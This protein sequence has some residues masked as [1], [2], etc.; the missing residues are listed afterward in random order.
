MKPDIYSPKYRLFKKNIET[1]FKSVFSI[2]N[3]QINNKKIT[4]ISLYC[5]IEKGGPKDDFSIANLHRILLDLASLFNGYIEGKRKI[6][7]GDDLNANK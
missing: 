7:L 1:Q 6:I 4:L 2:G 5:L 3:T